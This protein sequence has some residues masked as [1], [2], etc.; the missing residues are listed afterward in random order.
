MSHQSVRPIC[1][2]EERKDNSEDQMDEGMDDEIR[3]EIREQGKR[4][5]PEEPTFEEVEAH[6]VDHAN[7]REWCPHCV[8]GKGI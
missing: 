8:R 7:Y 5:L 2:I 1:D 6:N 4:R 3:P